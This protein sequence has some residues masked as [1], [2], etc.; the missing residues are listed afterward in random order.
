MIVE[1]LEGR[2]FMTAWVL[3]PAAHRSAVLAE[4][5]RE[6]NISHSRILNS[7]DLP[8]PGNKGGRL[9]LLRATSA[10]RRDLSAD[11]DLGELWE[12]LEG[13][14]G[15][16]AYEAL[17]QLYF[18]RGASADDVSALTRAV[19]GDGLKFRFSPEGAV[20]H[21]REE[22]DQLL[23]R[24]QKEAEAE[25]AALAMA[26]WLAAYSG[27]MPAPEPPEGEQARELLLNLA[28]WGDKAPDRQDA[29][30]LLERAGLTPD[31]AGAFRGLVNIGEFTRHENLELRRLDLPL[32]FEPEIQAQV[33]ALAA[34]PAA[35]GRRA[36]RLDLTALST[37][38]IDSNGARDLD[39]AISI[40]SLAGGRC[41]VGVHITDVAALVTPDSELDQAARARA[42]SVYL[43][44]GKYPMLPAELSEGLLSLTPGD[45]KPALSILATLEK[46]G[47][48][49][50][51]SISSS[52]IRVDRQLSFS[53]ADQ[54]M[55][56]DSDLVDLWDLAQALIARREGQ[57]GV[58]LNIPK[59][60][61][62][63]QPDGS[64]G[65]GLTQ[66]DTPAKTI[67]GELMILANNLAADYLYKNGYPCP[68][69]YQEK[70][71]DPGPA[72]SAASKGP[73]TED[74]DLALS[75]AARR[76]TGRSGLSFVPAP[77]HGLG[78]SVYT[79]FTAP[80]RRYVD[81]LVARQLRS[82][83]EGGPPAM[84]QQEFL[85]L[86]LPAYEL[87]Q[88]IQKMQNSRQ[89][90]WLNT[91]LADKAG[92]EFSALVFE[93]NDR[94][95]RVCVTDYML[96]TDL[97]LPKNDGARA[98]SLFGRRLTVKLASLSTGDTPPRFEVVS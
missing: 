98:P 81:L 79:A 30:K 4:N 9:E 77:H 29:K 37:L 62:Y 58:N 69:R 32:T 90:Y 60:N 13:E 91:H 72:E 38:T 49:S 24:R 71:R 25:R 10:A 89:R 33:S 86:A 40:K 36:G 50:E 57:G 54:N 5:G 88:K 82:L 95:L 21:S 66:W 61:V 55:D 63:F 87:A 97:F 78:L 18:G 35:A 65:V 75:L 47:Q 22:L 59:L 96:E 2:D 7:A 39:D 43:P 93:Q 12:I 83:A 42:S 44:E 53:E 1:F 19:F 67:V 11:I 92:R 8:D 16:F 84:D 52:L 85:R 41:Q 45:V 94:R 15:P 31:E 6:M 51:Y 20:R 56:E 28:L 34:Q 64:L 73:R 76:R 74:L 46:D 23:V 80:M 68:Y 70:P 17:A 26:E 27:G 14:P 48:V 3:T